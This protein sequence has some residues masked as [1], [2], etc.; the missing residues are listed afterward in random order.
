MGPE[1]W[2]GVIT[3]NR[4][5]PLR[6]PTPKTVQTKYFQLGSVMY[7]LAG[8]VEQSMVLNISISSLSGHSFAIQPSPV[9]FIANV[10]SVQVTSHLTLSSDGFK[11]FFFFF[12]NK[13]YFCFE[14]QPLLVF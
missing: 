8:T 7:C 11:T 5:S 14:T 3:R 13:A 10:I 6:S 12:F 1:F 2:S 9:L 4:F